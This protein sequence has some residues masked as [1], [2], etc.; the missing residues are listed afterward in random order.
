MRYSKINNI[1]FKKN[2]IKLAKKLEKKSVAVI[3]S[4]DEMPKNGDIKFKFCQN[5]DIFYLTGIEQEKTVLL[6]YY[7]NKSKK[8]KEILFII[9]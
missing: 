4:N 7:H 2:R 3:N 9:K 8:F 6:L 5:S 1:L